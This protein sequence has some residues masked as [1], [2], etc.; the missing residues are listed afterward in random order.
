VSSPAAD[1]DA[2]LEAL[3]AYRIA[4]V[5]LLEALGCSGSNRD[6]FAEFAERIAVAALGGTMAAS[7]TQKG[8]DFTD[9][10]RRRVQVRYLANPAGPWVNEHLVDFRGGHCDR[11]ALLVVEAFEPKALLVFEAE[12]LGAV[13]VALAKRHGDQEHTLQ[14]TQRNYKALLA[15]PARFAAYGVQVLDLTRGWELGPAI[16]GSA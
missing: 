5:R 12:H 13:G 9:T 10:E 7:R 14:L 3:S 15:E 8:W 4:R 6:P 16:E 11:Y 2:L 1:V